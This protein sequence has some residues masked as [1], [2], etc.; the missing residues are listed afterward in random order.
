MCVFVCVEQKR[1]TGTTAR[2]SRCRTVTTRSATATT[3]TATS[4]PS[5]S[6]SLSPTYSPPS[7]SRAEPDVRCAAVCCSHAGWCRALGQGWRVWG[8]RFQTRTGACSWWPR[9]STATTRSPPHMANQPCICVSK[10]LPPAS[11]RSACSRSAHIHHAFGP[12]IAD[13]HRRLSVLLQP[14]DILSR[15]PVHNTASLFICW[16]T[17]LHARGVCD[18][19]R[20][21]V[22]RSDLRRVGLR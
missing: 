20:W 19:W 10:L 22:D 17:S 21:R 6:G 13:L 14:A 3:R 15:R 18:G 7:S 9:S 2:T 4:Q 11:M 1:G 8:G 12:H 5:P 16:R